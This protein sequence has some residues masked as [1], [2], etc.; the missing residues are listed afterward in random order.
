MYTCIY[1]YIMGTKEMRHGCHWHTSTNSTGL[2]VWNGIW[3]DWV[4]SVSGC[5]VSFAFLLQGYRVLRRLIAMPEKTMTP[6][7]LEIVLLLASPALAPLTE[8]ESDIRLR[9]PIVNSRVFVTQGNSKL[10]LESTRTIYL[11]SLRLITRF[12]F[13]WNNHAILKFI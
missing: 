12:F 10:G 8:F 2:E 6:A 5:W 3:I 7:A 9:A 11:A 13:C 4:D 1:I